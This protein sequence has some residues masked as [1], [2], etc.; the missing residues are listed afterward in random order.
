MKE[1]VHIETRYDIQLEGFADIWFRR[2][3]GS[4][5]H[6]VPS[7][8]NYVRFQSWPMHLQPR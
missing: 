7:L 1:T 6:S 2:S 4:A 8:Q 5:E 3:G